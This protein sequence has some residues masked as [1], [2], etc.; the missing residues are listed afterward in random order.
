M[1]STRARWRPFDV[2]RGASEVPLGQRALENS[3]G[4][5]LMERWWE[6]SPRRETDDEG[7]PVKGKA[8]RT[9]SAFRP[10][11]E[12]GTGSDG[13]PRVVQRE[14]QG[15]ARSTVFPKFLDDLE[16]LVDASSVR[17]K[18]PELADVPHDQLAAY[19]KK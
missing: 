3:F 9:P 17:D 4:N 6:G 1:S 2:A 16:A 12:R 11:S 10:L 15:V 8:A 14:M 19:F 7:K 18:F 13:V 5:G